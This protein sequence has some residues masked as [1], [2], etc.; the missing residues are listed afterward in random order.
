MKVAFLTGSL[1]RQGGGFF[2]IMQRLSAELTYRGFQVEALGTEDNDYVVDRP[3]WGRTRTSAFKPLGPARLSYAPALVAGLR[4]SNP[5]L[6]H[7]HGIWMAVSAINHRWHLKHGKPYLI[8]AQGMLNRWAL[9]HQHWKKRI[10]GLLYENRNL[11][12]AACLHAT[13]AQE[14][15][16]YR[17]YGLRNPIAVIPNAVD[18]PM[19]PN[20]NAVAPWVDAAPPG[21]RVLR[22]IGRL[23]PKKGL[24]ELLEGWKHARGNRR[25]WKL[26]IAGWDEVGHRAELE[27]RIMELQLSNEVTLIGPQF[28][29]SKAACLA[30]ADAFIL[31]SHSEGLP[32]AVLEVWAHGLPTIITPECNLPIGFDAGAAI[33]IAPEPTSISAGLETLFAMSDEE[34]TAMGIQGRQLVEASFTWPAIA[35]QMLGTYRWMLGQG[36]KPGCVVT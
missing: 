5:D 1:S 23:H 16:D 22:F 25:G 15:E 10:A 9:Q 17:K 27:R 18:I 32:M 12:D 7:L 11:R 30:N 26:V 14:V 36:P 29:E 6:V 8:S 13:S 31:P 24:L 34:R 20:G 21:S 4:D 35:E 3:T 19:G 33:R 28:G 2:P